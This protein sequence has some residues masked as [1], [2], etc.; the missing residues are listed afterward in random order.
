MNNFDKISEAIRYI[1]DNLADTLS[2]ELIA[3]HFAFSP[4]YFCRLFTAVVGKI[5]DCLRSRQ[6]SCFCVQNAD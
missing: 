2:V 1:D 5:F 6:T 4:Y 3:E